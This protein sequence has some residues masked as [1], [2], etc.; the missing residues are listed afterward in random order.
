[1]VMVPH[2]RV[3]PDVA[4]ALGRDTL[5]EGD[6]LS[7]GA[8]TVH[9]LPFCEQGEYDKLLWSCDFNIVRGE[10]S[11]MR[12]QWAARPFLWHI[13]PQDENAHIIKLDAFLTRY[14]AAMD[15]ASRDVLQRAAHAWNLEQ[16]IARSWGEMTENWPQLALH[17]SN[18]PQR[19][20]G[21]SSLS[22]RLVQM[23]EKQLQ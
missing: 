23:V 11:F 2:G 6:T 4:A 22:A 19:A 8:L 12:A 15:E 5:A 10:D 3:L 13:Y 18:W 16:D 1:R 14:T 9:V 20:L 17:A 21:S 7:L